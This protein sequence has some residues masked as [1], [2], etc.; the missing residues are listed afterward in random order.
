MFANIKIAQRL[1]LGFGL[2]LVLAGVIGL[3]GYIAL[4]ASAARFADLTQD[5]NL[6]IELSNDLNSSVHIT[7]RV[8]RSVV[9]ENDKDEIGEELKKLEASR[10]QY[11]KDWATLQKLSASEAGRAIRKKL[12]TQKQRRAQSMT[13]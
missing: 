7:Q 10:N 13:R 3:T 1:S 4:L 9:L 12:M 5:N 2:I 11:D 6:K 8:I